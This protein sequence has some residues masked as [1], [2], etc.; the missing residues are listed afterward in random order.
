M[1]KLICDRCKKE[2]EGD[3]YVHLRIGG[4]GIIKQREFDLCKGCENSLVIFLEGKEGE[5]E[6]KG[7]TFGI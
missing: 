5:P 1:R 4:G 6:D 2:I 7:R 3:E